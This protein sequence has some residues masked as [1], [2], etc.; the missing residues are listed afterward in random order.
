[1]PDGSAKTTKIPENP[2]ISLA[3]DMKKGLHLLL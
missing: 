1:M 2:R 3:E